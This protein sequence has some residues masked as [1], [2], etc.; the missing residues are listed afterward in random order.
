MGWMVNICPICTVI[1]PTFLINYFR[2]NK[3]LL[4]PAMARLLHIRYYRSQSNV[5]YTE[6][7]DN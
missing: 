3:L 7:T 4:K 2:I 1:S 6:G 5:Y